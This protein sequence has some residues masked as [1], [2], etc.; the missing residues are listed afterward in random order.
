MCQYFQAMVPLGK[1]KFVVAKPLALKSLCSF[2]CQNTKTPPLVTLGWT[3]LIYHNL[4]GSLNTCG[5]YMGHIGLQEHI[6]GLW[7]P[8]ANPRLAK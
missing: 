3:G 2:I 1:V 7:V 8:Q 5:P 4:I 6:G